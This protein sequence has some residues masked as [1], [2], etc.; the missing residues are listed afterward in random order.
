MG[1]NMAESPPADGAPSKSKVSTKMRLAVSDGS[2]HY[3]LKVPAEPRNWN[4][5]NPS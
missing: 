5:A 3:F 2:G 4:S 1:V